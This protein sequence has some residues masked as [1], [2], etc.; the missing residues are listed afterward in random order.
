MSNLGGAMKQSVYNPIAI[1][2]WFIEKSDDGLTLMQL[3]KLSYISHGFK[4][5]LD[6]GPMSEELVEAWKYGPVFPS[7]YHEFKYEPPGKIKCLGTEIDEITPV[8]DDFED[9]DYKILEL[10]NDIYSGVEGWQL[11][12][13]THV[14]GTP[15]WDSYHKKGGNKLRGVTIENSEIESHF[16]NNIIQKYNVSIA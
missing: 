8:R 4:L 12:A 5:G 7:I 15:W 14:E 11:S 16:K 2:N 13:L 10:V 3:L 9:H 1:A 6:M